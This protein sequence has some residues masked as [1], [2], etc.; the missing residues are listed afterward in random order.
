MPPSNVT[1]TVTASG[2]DD[3]NIHNDRPR[4]RKRLV[5]VNASLRGANQGAPPGAALNVYPFPFEGMWEP[6]RHGHYPVFPVGT[7]RRVG[8]FRRAGMGTLGGRAASRRS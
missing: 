2:R 1:G 7:A 5:R 4:R 3:P 8:A 6:A